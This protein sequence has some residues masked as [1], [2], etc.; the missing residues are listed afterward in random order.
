M[1]KEN[2]IFIFILPLS[3]LIPV[4]SLLLF[5]HEFLFS[6][7]SV[8]LYLIILALSILPMLIINKYFSKFKFI[9]LSIIVF[10]FIYVMYFPNEAPKLSIIM[11]DS[12]LTA[13]LIFSFLLIFF[14]LL[15][16]R[17]TNIVFTLFIVIFVLTIF[18][19]DRSTKEIKTYFY[20]TNLKEDY[21]NKRYIH[22]IL[23]QHV[24]LDG[25]KENT[26]KS[27]NF[28]KKLSTEY[29]NFGF[30]IYPK[31]YVQFF[32]TKLSIPSILNF[33]SS[34]EI[35][36][37][38]YES[39]PPYISLKQNKLFE[40]LS[41]KNYIINAYGNYLG[42]CDP[43]YTMKKCVTYRRT[44]LFNESESVKNKVLLVLDNLLSR[45]RLINI[46]NYITSIK[47]NDKSILPSYNWNPPVVDKHTTA[48]LETFDILAEDILNSKTG[49]AFFA[50]ILFPHSPYLYNE[51]CELKFLE[52]FRKNNPSY[53]L[54]FA[55]LMCCQKKIIELLQMMKERNLLE[56]SVIVIHGDHGPFYL[57]DDDFDKRNWRKYSTFFAIYD[58][59]PID[60]KNNK[61]HN[62]YFTVS[63]LLKSFF[64]NNFQI[65]ENSKLIE[66]QKTNTVYIFDPKKLLV[67][68]D[69]LESFKKGN[70]QN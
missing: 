26:L 61:I 40:Y 39:E 14:Y 46:Y 15:K 52:G 22:I 50:H 60:N 53:A 64:D 19:P 49:E 57:E 3:I 37:E 33:S 55:Q 68:E 27:K 12:K 62:N 54:Y 2:F 16:K 43:K 28:K 32:Q 29:L 31:A 58:G 44:I 67:R 59:S 8:I 1:N 18:I 63:S 70:T 42:W 11:L 24:G 48:S 34:N 65:K 45:Y 56:N 66:S 13:L 6:K 30:D 10:L 17:I 20:D 7:A 23:D 4:V 5:N 25:I 41:N 36:L 51:N 21:N 35:F 47:F 38:N 9:I 69:I